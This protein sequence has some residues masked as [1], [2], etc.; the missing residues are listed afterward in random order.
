MRSNKKL[1]ISYSLSILIHV[2][3]LLLLNSLIETEKPPPKNEPIPVIY[4]KNM[5]LEKAALKPNASG[6]SEYNKPVKI[7]SS[8]VASRKITPPQMKKL[9]PEKQSERK[10]TKIPA[11]TIV[12]NI[13]KLVQKELRNKIE[14][15][16][17]VKPLIKILAPKP[18]LLQ[19]TLPKSS[20]PESVN[21]AKKAG[22]TFDEI[23]IRK[24]VGRP[25]GE[26]VK[27]ARI[28]P[29]IRR[30]EELRELE[31]KSTK[32]FDREVDTI[33][34]DST[35][36]KYAS[37]LDHIKLAIEL[38][39]NYPEAAARRGIQG[40]G[41]IYFSIDSKGE[42]KEIKLVSSTGSKI[43][44]ERFIRA[45]KMAAPFPT[46]PPRFRTKR[47]KIFATYR[48][49]LNMVYGR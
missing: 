10:K 45:V 30:L 46:L 4:Y 40:K 8:Q 27:I 6:N 20:T 22:N 39:W 1:I 17:S 11:K 14:Q 36:I 7:K 32:G 47:L 41:V 31:S 19:I 26:G 15:K 48:Y 16:S 34:L 18:T 43:L 35:N 28:L 13:E 9:V 23:D 42:L 3:F 21:N 2:I 25:E 44:D 49:I 24:S 29:S 33:Y 12:K 5:P 38:A 37:Y